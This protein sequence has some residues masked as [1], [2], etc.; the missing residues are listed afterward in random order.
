MKGSQPCSTVSDPQAA[1]QDILQCLAHLGFKRVFRELLQVTDL[2]LPAGNQPGQADKV[3]QGITKGAEPTFA[4]PPL[5]VIH[6]LSLSPLL[7][8]SLGSATNQSL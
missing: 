7:G 5:H 8:Q 4:R 1:G 3:I 6:N 2:I